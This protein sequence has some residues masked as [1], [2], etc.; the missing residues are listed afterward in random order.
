MMTETR[1]GAHMD[2]DQKNEIIICTSITSYLVKSPVG[3][4]QS[5]YTIASDRFTNVDM[6]AHTTTSGI[7][8]KC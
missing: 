7:V 5:S 3:T 6:Q 4:L 1:L 8:A 2:A